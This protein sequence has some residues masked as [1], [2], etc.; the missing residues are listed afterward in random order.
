MTFGARRFAKQAGAEHA[1]WQYFDWVNAGAAAW[2]PTIAFL[3]EKNLQKILRWQ[4]AAR[5]AH[6]V[7]HRWPP[8]VAVC[9]SKKQE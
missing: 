7:A 4:N 2:K 3:L 9:S 1:R 5:L 8:A 6:Y